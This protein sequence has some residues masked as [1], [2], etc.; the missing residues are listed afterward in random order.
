MRGQPSACEVHT[1]ET[2]AGALAFRAGN[3]DWRPLAGGTD[4]MVPFAAGRL[5]DQRFLN[6]WG[7]RELKG[8]LASEDAV[9]IGALASYRAIAAHPVIQARLPNLV[10]SAR[11][12][13][14]LAIQGRGTLGGNLVNGSPAAD[15]PPSL[16]VYEAEVELASVRGG[17]WIPYAAFHT[18]YRANAMAPDELLTCIRV[19]LPPEGGVHYFRKVGT[20]QA[21]AI[22]KLSLAGWALPRQGRLAEIRLALGSVAPVPVR[23][24]HAETV[25]RGAPLS[26]LPLS[27]AREALQADIAPIDDLRSSA[28]YRRRVAGNLL[29]EALAALI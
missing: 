22:A 14:A 19:P 28:R 13:G 5:G 12:T 18:G 20:R 24:L 15:S 21:Q 11:A 6:L 17:R 26:A 23:A 8:I 7:L 1:P 2:L 27:A 29:E 16:L 4:L 25:L 3:P 10:A 9:L